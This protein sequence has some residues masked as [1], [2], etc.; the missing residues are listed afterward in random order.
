MNSCTNRWNH[1]GKDK[2]EMNDFFFT[3]KNLLQQKSNTYWHIFYL[4][5]YIS[6]S[7]VPFGLRIQLFPHFNEISSEFKKRWEATL[8]ECSLKL[9]QLLINEYNDQL[10][11]IDCEIQELWKKS[12][13]FS[14]TNEFK[15]QD[16]NLKEQVENNGCITISI[17]E[18]KIMRDRKAFQAKKSV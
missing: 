5:K 13:M 12:S 9:M 8:T 7:I 14:S 16:R 6:E 3:A 18:K 17:K 11:K 15:E 10:V 2:I 4:E 1:E